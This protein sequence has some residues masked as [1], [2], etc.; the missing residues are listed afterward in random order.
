[1]KLTD[2]LTVNGSP[3]F[4]SVTNNPLSYSNGVFNVGTLKTGQAR[5]NSVTL[6]IM[7][8][9]DAV[10]N[11]QCLM[12]TL[13]GNPPPGVGPY[14]DDI[15]D[16]VAKVCLGEGPAEL[17]QDGTV[18]VWTLQACL[19]NVANNA[20]DTAAEVDVG[21]LTSIDGNIHHVSPVI[22]VKDEPGRVFDANSGSVTDG[23][24]VSWQT[25]TDEDP[26]FTGT[27]ERGKGRIQSNPGQ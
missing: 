27:R 3:S 5:I 17:F 9:S 15:S 10:V 14:D 7:V 4:T 8:A 26:D 20:C 22:H 2:G 11:K 23:N 1:M 12:A 21:I 6:P 25:A 24:T 16:N 18:A 19:G 13:T